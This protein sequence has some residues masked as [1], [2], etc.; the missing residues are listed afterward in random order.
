MHSNRKVASVNNELRTWS[1]LDMVDE[2]VAM[3]EDESSL[4]LGIGI[5][6]LVAER[7]PADK[8]IWIHSENGVLG[9]SGRPHERNCLADV[10]QRRQRNHFGEIR[11][12]LF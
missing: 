2:V 4:N 1:K 6:T 8:N 11:S 10:D 12:E 5:P 9:V 3:L 7:I